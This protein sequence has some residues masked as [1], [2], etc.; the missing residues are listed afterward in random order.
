MTNFMSLNVSKY[1]GDAVNTV[2]KQEHCRLSEQGASPLT[3]SQWAW[4]KSYS[5]GRSAEA[6]ASRRLNQLNLKTS[7]AWAIKEN[8]S[9]FWQYSYKG[10]AN[11]FFDI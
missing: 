2:R 10:A 7:R 11:R 9:A 6:I 4:L 8:F 1:L 5:K 3:G